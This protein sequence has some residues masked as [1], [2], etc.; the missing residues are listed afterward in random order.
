[1]RCKVAAAREL[2]PTR[3]DLAEEIASSLKQVSMWASEE[4]AAILDDNGYEHLTKEALAASPRG[5]ERWARLAD[6]H[7]SEVHSLLNEIQRWD[8][9]AKLTKREARRLDELADF[10]ET[11]NLNDISAWPSASRFDVIESGWLNAV[12]ELGRFDKGLL[13][14]Q[15]SLLTEEMEHDVRS[16]DREHEHE[17]FYAL[18]DDAEQRKLDNWSEVNSA[19]EAR[20]LALS[21][22]PA[23]YGCAIVG[24]RALSTHPSQ[25]ETAALISEVFP[26][27]SHRVARFAV[28]AF[29]ILREDE[30]EALWEIAKHE[31]PAVRAAA[32]SFVDVTSDEGNLTEVATMLALDTDRSVQIAAL[33]RIA[34]QTDSLVPGLENLLRS[35]ARTDSKPFRCTSCGAKNDANRRSSQECNIVNERPDRRATEILES[36]G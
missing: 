25:S 23:S 13:A 16:S 28:L 20:Q 3:P 11:L 27:L 36:L 2:L 24:A 35:L 10:V 21:T 9:A 32:T 5:W 26:N 14:A 17:A 22:L 8:S 15:A 30:D 33:D 34:D 29:L 4:L 18:F 7:Q 12:A 19:D 1:M 6:G 31:N